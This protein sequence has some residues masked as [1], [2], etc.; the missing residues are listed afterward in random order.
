LRALARQVVRLAD[1]L[2]SDGALALGLERPGLVSF[3]F[4]CLFQDQQEVESNLVDPF[5]PVT[6]ADFRCFLECFLEGGYRA[7]SPAEIAE[8]LDPKG[9][10]LCI[11]FDDGY[12]NN[13]RALP[14]LREFG[15][16]ATIFVATN[17]IREGRAYWWDVQYRERRRRA[18]P[19]GESEAERDALKGLS[20]REI[21]A[22]LIE[23]FGAEAFAPEGEI[24]RPL[25]EAELK[26][27]ADEPLIT[28]GNHTSDHAI[29]TAHDEADI[30][31]QIA[32]CQDYLRDLLGRAPEVIAY[33]NGNYDER[34]LAAARD[35]GFRIGFV[36]EPRKVRLPIA[37]D[38][39]LSLPRFWI[40]GG[41]RTLA[42]SRACRS[43]IQVRNSLRR[44]R[45]AMSG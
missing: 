17:Y 12:A 35:Q 28:I 39:R 36:V 6:L 41:P 26:A 11:T 13:L 4:H 43:D 30:A 16:P 1:R 21:T 38:E 18:M 23:A 29:L 9:R 2:A 7:V 31:E 15:V 34:T 3:L 25:S 33:P 27:L 24:D 32:G 37:E 45:A 10:H 40:D 42:E 20:H 19:R 8:G 5:Q 14:L 44:L 22:R